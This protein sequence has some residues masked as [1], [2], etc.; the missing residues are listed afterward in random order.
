[1]ESSEED[2]DFPSIESITPQSKID[3]LHQS[4]T[5]KGIRKLCCELLDLKDAVENLC[6]NMQTKYL[7]F[8]RI[9]E[10][11]REMQHESIELRK[12]ISAQ[13]I[14]VQDLMTGVSRELEE[15]N[16]SGGEPYEAKQDSK[17]D[18]LKDLIPNE[19]DANSIFLENID[20]LLA[21]HKV[22]EAL[23]AL[24]SEE[25]NS[26]E[27]KNSDL[28][29]ADESSYKAAF[30]RRKVILED[31][32]VEIAE[33]PSISVVE[34][35][36]TLCALIKLG[37]G[38]LAHQLLLKFYGSRIQKNIEVFIPSCSFCPRTYPATL[39]KIVFSIISHTRKESGLIF[40][41]D[42]VYTNRIVQW[43]E[44][45]IEAFVRMIKE[46]A[47]ISETVSALR[48]ASV[49]VQASLNYCLAL[50]SQGL[51][52]SKLVLV[53]LHPFIEEVLELNFRR[54][55]KVVLGSVEP[56]E[57]IPFSPRFASLLSTITPSPDSV[58]V[59]SGIRFMS[60]VEDILEQLTPLTV[61]HFGGNILSRIGHLFDKYMDSLIKA[62]PGPSDDDNI[63]ELKDV[64][65]FRAETDSEQLS[66]LGIAFTIM[67]ELLP[68]A[69]VT[70]WKQLNGC[71]D[72]NDGTG[73]NMKSS[74]STN[75]L[76][77]W[78]RQIQHSY[79]KLRD[80]FCRQYVLA[81]IYSR[82]GKTRLNAQ[83]Y[84]NGNGDI[85][86]HWDSD[87][88]PSLPFQALFSKLQ[89]LAT[90][91]GDVLLGK[92]KIQKNLLARLT[93]TVL[94]WL[95]DE[96]EF[97]DVFEDDSGP[98]EPLGLQ[99]LIL[100]MHFTVEIARFAGYPSRHVHQIASAIIARAIRAFSSEGMVS[101]NALPEDEWFVDAAKLAINKLLLGAEGSEASEID[102]D[103]LLHHDDDVISDSDDTVSSLSSEESFE[104]FVS[105]SMGDLDSPSD[106]T[107][108]ES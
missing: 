89:Q 85:L 52:L 11:A 21:E 53:L 33:Q 68:N 37:K 88:L 74:P 3:S 12:H 102:E 34:L 76:K 54:A 92:E 13:G 15:W 42:P 90:V 69:V 82:E 83:I 50:E 2:D 101:N 78:K 60:I 67:D 46:N 57:I 36:K 81:F 55:R 75:A 20:V 31:Q 44:W 28:L 98:L 80:H 6:G 7:A 87:P 8:L 96:Q 47:P 29:S 107:D 94:M 58:L 45:E 72:S 16:K 64:V 79:D 41:D 56:E 95:S 99:Q 27:L 106:L 22:E 43:A 61:L 73:E 17:S 51:K 5:E 10:E 26:L 19:V 77:E 30:L 18:E 1:M 66:I 9:S 24:D 23:D 38:P 65:P 105:A 108:P 32:L 62:L 97:W 4:H 25:K 70:V 103:D 63:T 14:L 40:G 86:H 71:Q 48:A 84:F 91:A 59:N 100:D 39:S 49:C 35:K 93:E 104:S